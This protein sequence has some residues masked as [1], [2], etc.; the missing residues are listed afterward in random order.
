[1][2]PEIGEDAATAGRLTIQSKAIKAAGRF[3]RASST[4]LG[5][6][7]SCTW[8]GLLQT[9]HKQT[10]V[11]HFIK[12]IDGL[13]AQEIFLNLKNRNARLSTICVVIRSESL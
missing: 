8:T 2:L 3:G 7:E 11:K 4:G 13:K 6:Y 5:N 9:V 10:D 1:M 12:F